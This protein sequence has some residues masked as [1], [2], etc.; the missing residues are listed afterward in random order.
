[1]HIAVRQQ[2]PLMLFSPLSPAATGLRR[3][4]SQ[5]FYETPE[6]LPDSGGEG[7]FTRLAKLFKG[8]PAQQ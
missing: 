4:V 8:G 1:M 2:T 5:S 6:N 3:I 7:F